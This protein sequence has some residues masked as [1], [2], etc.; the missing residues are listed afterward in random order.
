M[1]RLIRST[2]VLLLALA[3]GCGVGPVTVA[4]TGS[5]IRGHVHGGQQPVSGATIQLYAVGATGDGSASM[6]LIASTVL[7]DSGGNFS[8]AGASP[9]R[10]ARR[11]STW[12][13]PAATPAW[14]A[15]PAISSSP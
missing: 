12:S 8:L 7:S 10:R 15:E 4:P 14:A 6:P 13:R 3:T 2:G 5:M 11:W 1:G 9:A